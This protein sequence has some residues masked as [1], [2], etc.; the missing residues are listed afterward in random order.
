MPLKVVESS[1][2]KGLRL[3]KFRDRKV[4]KVLQLCIQPLLVVSP[5]ERK[6]TKQDMAFTK[7][8]LAWLFRSNLMVASISYR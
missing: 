6:M 8:N 4:Q 2:K 1:K 5:S 3:N 7:T